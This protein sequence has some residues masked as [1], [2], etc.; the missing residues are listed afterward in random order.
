MEVQT[1]AELIGN[2][3]YTTARLVDEFGKIA[4]SGRVARVNTRSNQLAWR[5]ADPAIEIHK[6]SATFGKE[7]SSTSLPE[8]SALPPHRGY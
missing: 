3:I 7:V 5:V 1:D 4:L 2:T 6:A 8:P